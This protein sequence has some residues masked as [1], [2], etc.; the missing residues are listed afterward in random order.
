MKKNSF[1]ILILTLCLALNSHLQAQIPQGINY[2]AVARDAQGEI[3]TNAELEVRF[4]I[5]TVFEETS[6]VEVYQETHTTTTNDYGL[7]TLVI[8]AK[9]GEGSIFEDIDWS[10]PQYLLKVEIDAGDG[11]IDLG[12]TPFQSVPYAFL[13]ESVNYNSGNPLIIKGEFTFD[14]L[15]AP[16]ILSNVSEKGSGIKILEAQSGISVDNARLYGVEVKNSDLH[17]L[18]VTNASQDG[19]F[20]LEAGGDGIEVRKAGE[21]G[22]EIDEAEQNGV[23][24]ENAGRDGV[25]VENAN[26][27]GG[28][29]IGENSGVHAMNTRDNGADLVLGGNIGRLTSDP[30]V[31]TSD[32]FIEANR[33]VKLR[34]DQ[35]KLANGVFEVQDEDGIPILQLFEETGELLITGPLTELSDVNQKINTSSI[36]AKAILAR[37][38]K[39][40]IYHWAYRDSPEVPHIGPMAQDFFAAFHLGKNDTS[41]STIDRDGV[42]LAA[43]Q[44]LYK[45]I[46]EKDMEISK[47][48]RRLSQLEGSPGN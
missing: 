5:F 43:I 38:M 20:I 48:A 45:L 8:G 25:Y 18:R 44:G 1:R 28:Y 37:L 17:G 31:N 14:G 10:S 26:N 32:L 34:L 40:P 12:I 42:A 21:N 27:Y 39:V 19:L 2:Q 22:L 16:V 4:I 3:L 11:F 15:D 36:D 24:V 30:E 29:F 23:F 7:F 47:L 9:T 46:Q 13:A 33:N 6:L 41:I 35:G